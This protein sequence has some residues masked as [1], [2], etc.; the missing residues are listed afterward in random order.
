MHCALWDF[1]HLTNICN[2]FTM[3][4]HIFIYATYHFPVTPSFPTFLPLPLHTHTFAFWKTFI[5]SL[6]HSFPSPFP[7]PSPYTLIPLLFY[8]F[9]RSPVRIFTFPTF[10]PPSPLPILLPPGGGQEVT[11]LPYLF[12]FSFLP[13]PAVRISGLQQ[14][15]RFA[16]LPIYLY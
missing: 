6:H 14:R 13:A 10:P 16:L 7:T 3:L 5:H 2:T 15:K 1:L 8:S 4:L 11:Y 9:H 12:P